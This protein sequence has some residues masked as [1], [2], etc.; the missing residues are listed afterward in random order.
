M[1]ARLVLAVVWIL[2]ATG[3]PAQLRVVY[4]DLTERTGVAYGYKILALALQKSGHPFTLTLSPEPISMDRAKVRL[5]TGEIS[6]LDV[7]TSA[8]FEDRWDAVPFPIDRGLSGYRLFFIPRDRAAAFLR[9]RT[10][11]DLRGFSAGQGRGWA[12][13]AILRGAGISVEEVS[14]FEALF[15]MV[16]GG[17]FDFFPLGVEEIQGFQNRFASDLTNA[18]IQPTLALHYPFG[19]LFFVRKGDKI[20]RDTLTKGLVAAFADGSLQQAFL[21]DPEVSASL[22]FADLAHRTVIE[23]PNP[24]LSDWFRSIPSQYFW[25]GPR[26]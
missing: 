17:R 5:D 11:S 4:P 2:A 18:E 16:N 12:D 24:T 10:L 7:G 15:R 25:S 22:R 13:T 19:R 8:E 26:N 23:I 1:R 6:V 21:K 20:L 14:E 3:L 9:V